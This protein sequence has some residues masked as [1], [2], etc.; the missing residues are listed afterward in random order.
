[1][2]LVHKVRGYQ[3]SR[4]D[5]SKTLG[6]KSLAHWTCFCSMKLLIALSLCQINGGELGCEEFTAQQ[7]RVS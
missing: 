7:T 6:A 1:M 3:Q 5:K 2:V 4:M